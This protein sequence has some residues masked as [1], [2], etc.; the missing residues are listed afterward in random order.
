MAEAAEEAATR[1]ATNTTAFIVN[2]KLN[3][4]IDEKQWGG[5]GSRKQF[6]LIE[7]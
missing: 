6:S 5:K 4:M 2:T 3:L 7:K 1:R